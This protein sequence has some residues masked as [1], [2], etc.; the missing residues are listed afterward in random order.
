MVEIPPRVSSWQQL[1]LD[2]YLAGRQLQV[3]E[4]PV[5]KETKD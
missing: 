2:Q 3:H 1:V 5:K 4:L